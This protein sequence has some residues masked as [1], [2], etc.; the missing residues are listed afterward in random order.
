MQEGSG[1]VEVAGGVGD[2]MAATASFIETLWR[3]GTYPCHCNR[4]RFSMLFSEVP[5]MSE[6]VGGGT[7]AIANATV[8]H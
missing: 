4:T 5:N 3:V 7:N 6:V 8:I 1:W 2:W